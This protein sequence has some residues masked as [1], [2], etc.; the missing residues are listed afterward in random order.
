MPATALFADPQTAA[1]LGEARAVAF[2]V[3]G[4]DGSGN[5]G[6]LALLEA[7]TRLLEPQSGELLALPVLEAGFAAQHGELAATMRSVPPH[8]LFFGEAAPSGAAPLRLAPPAAAAVYLYGGGFLNRAWGERKL[9]MLAAIEELLSTAPPKRVLRVASGLQVDPAWLAEL[10]PAAATGLTGF[11]LLGGR[12]EDSAAALE[13]LAGPQRAR[14]WGDDAVGLLRELTPARVPAAN[15]G[16]LRVNAHFGVHEWAG[17][18]PE[19]VLDLY[20]EVVAQLGR[21]RGR[22]VLVRPLVAYLDRRIDERPALARMAAALEEAGATVAAPLVLRPGEPETVAAAIGGADLTL[23]GSFHVALA[24]LM[25]ATPAALVADN[26][27]FAQ[28]ARGLLADFKLPPAFA[29]ATGG[30]PAASAAAL[31]AGLDPA[32]PASGAALRERALALAERRAGAE[33]ELAAVFDDLAAAATAAP[34][35]RRRQLLGDDQ[36]LW[37]VRREPG[38]LSFRAWIAGAEHQVHV[39]TETAVTP[40][41][42]AA[43]A[44]AL[45]P[46]MRRGGRLRVEGEVSPRVLR[47]ATE[48]G[49][50]QAAWS[51][52]W[53]DGR[54]LREVEVEAGRRPVEPRAPTGR[55]A[56][57]FS[58]GVDSWATILS[59]P[60]LT[61]LIFVHGLD[62]VPDLL[63]EQ[64]GLGPEVEAA[65]REVAAERGLTLHVV[66]TNVRELGEATELEWQAYCGS[67]MA[68]IAL[69]FEPLFD[70]V[71]IATDSDH[72]TQPTI[73]PARMVDR[74]WSSERLEVVD[75]GGALGRFERTRLLA[76]EPGA[77]RSLRVCWEN[78]GG[79]YNCGRCRKCHLT[80]FALEALGVREH[81]TSFPPELDLDV[82]AEFTPTRE[83]QI[84]LYRDLL[85][86]LRECD[87][88]DLAARLEPALERGEVA[89]GMKEREQAED[90]EAAAEAQLAEL[91]GSNSWKLTEPLRRLGSRAKARVG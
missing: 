49:A 35:P 4:Y 42:D 39:R 90:R 61:D 76:W 23:S 11:E 68:A 13:R 63:P 41:A 19:A 89:L 18:R 14:R 15:G 72:L 87:R 27:Y 82:F 45:M 84:V 85:A 28:K 56:A 64:R 9:A 67:P 73:G 58:G 81:F 30:D 57:F 71:L 74:L 33:R 69:F 6:D 52:D 60:E 88:E 20:R 8:A 91:L 44:L 21:S 32:G 17:E 55:V 78:R 53:A 46:A 48:F 77:R 65:M 75:Q 43:L 22:E 16:P 54:P 38:E 80:T 3:G 1:A 31:V 86:G 59:E 26:D 2:L 5:Y 24:A 51:G 12:D 37:Q 83:I 29:L 66:E 47:G 25:A 62:I 70:R 7:A 50:I 10:D 36:V 40:P 79:R 34:P